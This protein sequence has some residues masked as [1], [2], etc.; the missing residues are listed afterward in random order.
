LE[1][2]LNLGR[3]PVASDDHLLLFR[4]FHPKLFYHISD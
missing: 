4:K 2:C 3:S 1:V